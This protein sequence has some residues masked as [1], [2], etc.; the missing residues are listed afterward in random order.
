[1][2]VRKYF[3]PSAKK[4]ARV[5]VDQIRQEFREVL[6]QNEWMDPVTKIAAGEKVDAITTHIG[7]PDELYDDKKLDEYHSSLEIDPQNY[8]MSVLNVNK[9]YLNYEFNQLRKPVNKT[10]W[11]AHSSSTFINA[12]Y[13]FEEN[14]I[15]LPAGIL[16]GIFFSADRP[17]YMNFGGGFCECLEI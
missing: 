13:S 16:Q 7:Y 1:M 8:F 14:S 9:F 12:Y 2:Y 10:D 11:I 3:K 6:K 4:I 5:M 15:E 17:S